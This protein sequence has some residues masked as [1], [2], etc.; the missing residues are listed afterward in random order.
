MA[1]RP[2]E[3]PGLCRR[4]GGE[5]RRDVPRHPAGLR[6]LRHRCAAR[7]ARPDRGGVGHAHVLHVDQHARA[8]PRARRPARLRRFGE[9][10]DLRRRA[11]PTRRRAQVHVGGGDQEPRPLHARRAQAHERRRGASTCH[12]PTA[13]TCHTPTASTCHTPTAST[14]QGFAT[15][16]YPMEESELSYA[17]GKDGTT[18]RKLARASGCIMEYVGQVAHPPPPAAPPRPPAARWRALP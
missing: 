4:V 2:A 17:L 9:A 15:D 13:S 5:G 7:D 3:G 18:R 14:W 8:R 1:V 10:R 12:T 16:T 6:R 11:R